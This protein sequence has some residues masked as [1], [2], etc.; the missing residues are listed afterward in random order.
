MTLPRLTRLTAGLLLLA[1][2]P[3]VTAERP[4]R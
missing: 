3:G 1:A 4:R 2:V